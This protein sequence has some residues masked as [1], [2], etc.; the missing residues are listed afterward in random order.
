LTSFIETTGLTEGLKETV[1]EDLRLALF[2]A[3]DVLLA[4]GG[5]FSEVCR[6]STR[7]FYN[8]IRVLCQQAL[9]ART[10]SHLRLSPKS[11]KG[12]A[13]SRIPDDIPSFN[14]KKIENLRMEFMPDERRRQLFFR[15][16]PCAFACLY[17]LSKEYQ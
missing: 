8:A 12:L 10:R 15:V 5:K 17:S 3:R 2:V 14:E 1:E 13:T 9:C 4:P 7:T 16:I 11:R 6:Y